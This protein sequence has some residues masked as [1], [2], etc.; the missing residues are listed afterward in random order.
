MINLTQHEGTIDQL[1]DGLVD[2]GEK[3]YEQVK[4]LLTM[5]V[6]DLTR[7]DV[8]AR[9]EQLRLLALYE[10]H[11]TGDSQ[12]MIGG[13]GWI[14]LPLQMVLEEVGFEVFF[15]TSN[16]VSEEVHMED[17]S[18]RKVNVFKHVKFLKM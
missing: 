16:R 8:W 4:D 15:A 6:E 2:L 18:V 13:A 3:A 12:V 17:G 1:E 5:E 7:E 14:M 9:A 10:R 11:K